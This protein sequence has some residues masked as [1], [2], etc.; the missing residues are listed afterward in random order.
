VATWREDALCKKKASEFWFPP[1]DVP[2]MA[3]YYNIGR[4]LCDRCPVWKHCLADAEENS[5][6]MGMWGGLI[7]K[8][9]GGH[10]KE[11]GTRVRYRQ[12]CSC[13][14]CKNANDKK[15]HKLPEWLIP[16]QGETFDIVE[17]K[18]AIQ[19]WQKSSK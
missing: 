7:P 6:V 13:L 12:G 2:A 3:Q 4:L 1:V 16:L 18:K 19:E 9:R 5:E 15:L 10:I 8:E 11:H 17:I 14:I